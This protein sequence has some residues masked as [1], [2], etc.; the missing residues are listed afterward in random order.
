MDIKEEII[1]QF[2]HLKIIETIYLF[3]SRVNNPNQEK[4]DIDL[5]FV[6][7]DKSDSESIIEIIANMLTK[8]NLLIHPI[9]FEKSDFERKMKIKNYQ[10]S[11]IKKGRIVY[12]R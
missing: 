11:I 10:E 8:S 3:G 2:E 6:I 4:S 7:N 1:P 5:C 12:S 9:I